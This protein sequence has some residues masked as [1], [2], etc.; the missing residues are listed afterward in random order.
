M[1]VTSAFQNGYLNEK[2]YV[3]QPL[4]YKVKGQEEKV[5]KLEKALY[6][7]KHAP[8]AWYN[9]NDEYFKN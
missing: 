6:G 9:R 4:N 5:L 1:D 7:L 3:Q 2:I 8:R